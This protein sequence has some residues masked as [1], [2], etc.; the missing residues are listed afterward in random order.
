MLCY[1]DRM[2]IQTKMHCYD[3]IVFVPLASLQMTKFIPL[4][5]I[6]ILKIMKD[7]NKEKKRN[8]IK[9]VNARTSI[10]RTFYSSFGLP[11]WTAYY[12]YIFNTGDFFSQFE[13]VFFFFHIF[14]S[15]SSILKISFL[16][17]FLSLLLG[18]CCFVKICI[19]FS[20]GCGTHIFISNSR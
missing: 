15:L 17:F 11:P 18:L 4:I 3:V 9:G 1:A 10:R 14:D 5:H 19:F 6:F 20:F 7:K 16:S 12:I 13:T 8:N 2:C